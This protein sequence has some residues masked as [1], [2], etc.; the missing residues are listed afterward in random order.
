M[1]GKTENCSL[2]SLALLR[3]LLS[4]SFCHANDVN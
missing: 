1:D 2:R 4:I 3:T